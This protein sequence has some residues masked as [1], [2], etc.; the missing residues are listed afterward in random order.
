MVAT[1]INISLANLSFAIDRN[2]LGFIPQFKIGLKLMIICKERASVTC[3][4]AKSIIE[5]MVGYLS[6]V[7]I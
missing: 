7:S 3:T 5:F 2:S 6:S 4:N 1:E